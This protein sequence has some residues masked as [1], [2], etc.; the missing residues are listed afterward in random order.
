MAYLSKQQ[1]TDIIKKAPPGTSPAGIVASLRSEGHQLEGFGGETAPESMGPAQSAMQTLGLTGEGGLLEP[2]I[3]F[4]K[5]VVR[6][7]AGMASMLQDIGKWGLGKL[8]VDTKDMG[9][10]SL[11]TKTPEGK[12]AQEYFEPKTT[13]QKVGGYMETVASILYPTGVGAKKVIEKVPAVVSKVSKTK[14]GK[15]VIEAVAGTKVME[16]VAAAR[17]PIVKAYQGGK[18]MIGDVVKGFSDELA[19]FTNKS[20]QALEVVKSKLK[21]DIDPNIVKQSLNDVIMNKF[22]SKDPIGYGLLNVDEVPKFKG[23][24]KYLN[25]WK[26]WSARG[27]LRL[28]EQLGKNYYNVGKHP[29]VSGIVND[30][31]KT[32]IEI[33]GDSN[34]TLKPALQKAHESIKFV[35]R[36]VQQFGDDV[37]KSESKFINAVNKI[38]DKATGQELR[39]LAQEFKDKTGMDLLKEMEGYVDYLTVKGKKWPGFKDI[40]GAIEY[41]ARKLLE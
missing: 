28:K 31:E 2:T 16:E 17:N 9:I 30:L 37:F 12:Y 1:V 19:S 15:G 35:D 3:G 34:K 11:D 32:L 26:D 20:K 5:G 40:P 13:G 18:K 21:G 4:A 38:K 39:R 36:F 33:V 27:V 25:D 24:I 8:G 7:G 23:M 41:G 10:K 6:E 14:A 22:G 29:N